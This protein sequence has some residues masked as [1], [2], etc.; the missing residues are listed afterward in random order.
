M[1]E[2]AVIPDFGVWLPRFFEV[3]EPCLEPDTTVLEAVVLA[4][5]VEADLATVDLL[6]VPLRVAVVA[7]GAGWVAEGAGWVASTEPGLSR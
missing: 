7:E 6:P 3:A 2:G 4:A 5:L 1:P